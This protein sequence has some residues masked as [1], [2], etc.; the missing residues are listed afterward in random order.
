[1]TPLL[2]IALGVALAGWLSTPGWWRTQVSVK[3]NK[4]AEL[5]YRQT[6]SPARSTNKEGL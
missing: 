6:E 1:M 3:A 5:R 2:Y 4:R